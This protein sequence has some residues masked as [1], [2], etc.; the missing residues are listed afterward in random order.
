MFCQDQ[1]KKQSCC[2]WLTKAVTLTPV[3]AGRA[4]EGVGPEVVIGQPDHQEGQVEVDKSKDNLKSM[5]MDANLFPPLTPTLA[6]W[7]SCG[8]SWYLLP[9]TE[10]CCSEREHS[11][12]LKED[13]W[14]ELEELP[15]GATLRRSVTVCM[16]CHEFRH[17]ALTSSG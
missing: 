8:G 15:V 11:E 14:W 12:K 7:V 1:W 2:A 17:L 4:V 13:I 10:V 5:R 9:Q 16:S 3:G 6:L